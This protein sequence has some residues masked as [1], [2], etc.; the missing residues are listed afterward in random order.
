MDPDK[1]RKRHFSSTACTQPVEPWLSGSGWGPWKELCSLL[2]ILLLGPK[3][4]LG[5]RHTGQRRNTRGLSKPRPTINPIAFS[6]PAQVI[7][8]NLESS[9][10]EGIAK[11]QGKEG[12]YKERWIIEVINEIYLVCDTN[13]KTC[14]THLSVS[15]V[16][17]PLIQ[18]GFTS[19]ACN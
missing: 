12:G 17:S 3:D 7:L 18:R 2:S 8:L 16:N 6:G 11:S 10:V 9:I 1:T 5:Q 14:K 15:T 13:G 19:Q 4:W